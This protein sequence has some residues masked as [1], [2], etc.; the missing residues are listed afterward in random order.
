MWYLG[1]IISAAVFCLIFCSGCVGL[2]LII[3]HFHRR[4]HWQDEVNLNNMRRALMQEL[5]IA[6]EVDEKGFVKPVISQRGR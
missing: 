6:Y 5:D 3:R 1:E 2:Y 4:W